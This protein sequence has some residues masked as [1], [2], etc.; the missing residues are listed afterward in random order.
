MDDK[1]P[2]VLWAYRTTYKRETNQTP[3]KLVYGQEA[4]VPLH[5][6]QHIYEIA[7]VLKIDTSEAKN[8]RM[9]QLQKLEEDRIMAIHHQEGHK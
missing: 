5:F 2:A 1:V 6:R 9:F 3:F 8:E 4:I 7:H